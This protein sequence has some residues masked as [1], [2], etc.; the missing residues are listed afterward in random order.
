[1]TKQ[2]TVVAIAGF[3]TLFSSVAFAG[4]L[5]SERDLEKMVQKNVEQRNAADEKK[6]NQVAAIAGDK[7]KELDAK[8]EETI[9]TYNIWRELNSAAEAS[10]SDTAKFKAIEAGEK[11][12]KANKEF[13][14][15]QK[16]V[17]LKTSDDVTVAEAINALNATA[18]TAA[19]R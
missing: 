12:A 15:M 1:M 17:L 7:R 3:I 8:R 13:V 11:H 5:A 14:E 2:N 6:Y 4:T 10:R 9:K 19:G 18:P 16:N